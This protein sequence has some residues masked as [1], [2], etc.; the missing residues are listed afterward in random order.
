MTRCLLVVVVATALVSGC[1]LQDQ[2]DKPEAQAGL[3]AAADWMALVDAGNYTGSWTA[4]AAYLQAAVPEDQW[5]KSLSAFRTPMGAKVS[6]VVKTARLASTLPGAPDGHYVLIQ[7][8]S[9]FANKKSAVETAT[10]MQETNGLWKVSGYF[11]R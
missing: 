3:R 9:S 5:V 11:I 6:R 8:D 7:Y 1:G 4:A 10:A 2:S